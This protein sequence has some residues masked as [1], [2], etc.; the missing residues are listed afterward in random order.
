MNLSRSLA[1]G[2][3]VAGSAKSAPSFSGV[4]AGMW[5]PFGI[6]RNAIRS[7]AFTAGAPAAH[8]ERGK[9]LSIKGRAIAV[10]RPRRNVRRSIDVML[11]VML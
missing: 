1:S 2:S 10:P 5:A 9:A 6:N 7:G 8:T 3:S 11:C 4:H